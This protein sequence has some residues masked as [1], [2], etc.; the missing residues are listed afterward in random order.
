MSHE[1]YEHVSL[2]LEDISMLA[3]VVAPRLDALLGESSW[4]RVG[5]VN[6]A[7]DVGLLGSIARLD[8]TKLPLVL[9]TNTVAPTWL[10]GQFVR[11]TPTATPLRIVNV[12]TGAAVRAFAGLGAYGASKAALRMAGMVL[13]AEIEEARARGDNAD[14]SILSFEP[15]TVDTAMQAAARTSSRETLPSLDMFTRFAAEGKLV[16]PAAPA[17]D[18]VSF[19]E[20][21]GEPL[22]NERR[23]GVR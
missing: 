5:L 20:S 23:H 4:S 10:M 21:D 15:G 7:A 19:L 1:R 18:V 12:S 6:N 16:A 14:V 9:A 11:R 2:D 22:F 8:I 3:S 13:A 17:S